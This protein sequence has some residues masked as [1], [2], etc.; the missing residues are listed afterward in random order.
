M[1][2]PNKYGTVYKLAGKRRHPWVAK[3]FIGKYMDDE[4]KT[5]RVKYQTIGYYKRRAEAYGAL[6]MYTTNPVGTTRS[7]LDCFN[8]WSAEHFPKIKSTG[9]YEA[10][11]S[12]LEPLWY[13]PMTSIK[14]DAIQFV[15]RD[16][17]KN[18]P[19]LKNVKILLGQ[20]F[21][22]AF[23]HE[24][25]PTSKKEMIAAIDI[26]NANPRAVVRRV[27]TKEEVEQLRNELDVTATMTMV[28]LYS[29]LRI[30]ELCAL[31]ESCVDYTRQALNI[32]AS[33]TAAGI[34]EVPIADAA[35]PYVRRYMGGERLRDYQYRAALKE[36]YN[37]LPHD[38]RHTFASRMTE[39]G[40][41]QRIIDA[42]LG[43]VGDNTALKVYTHIS[44]D[45]KLDAVN[46]LN[47]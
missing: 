1:R 28:L 19:T 34:R 35:M 25:I 16:S 32:R 31:D 42:I 43:H 14:L 21:D 11:W 17:G 20:L 18:T 39:A 30:S 27:F 37:H 40:A 29:G 15:L 24:Y 23:V 41:D 10:A 45:A 22:Y 44:L 33:K 2:L 46:L 8:A 13:E 7:L 47:L 9:H 4:A 5:V 26:G 3:K 36:R 6:A 12:V 38:T